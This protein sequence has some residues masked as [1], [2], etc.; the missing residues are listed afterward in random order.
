[1]MTLIGNGTPGPGFLFNSPRHIT[2]TQIDMGHSTLLLVS[3]AQQLR[4]L[5]SGVQSRAFVKTCRE[6]GENFEWDHHVF[7]GFETGLTAVPTGVMPAQGIDTI[8]DQLSQ[9]LRPGYLMV[10][11]RD[12]IRVL[13]RGLMPRLVLSLQVLRAGHEVQIQSF[14]QN[15]SAKK[16][17]ANS[18]WSLSA[19]QGLPL[20]LAF[21]S[22][23]AILNGASDPETGERLFI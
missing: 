17:V 10:S 3:P 22:F 5:S 11:D 18:S 2:P 16:L 4:D 23:R 15:Q 13:S 1:M 19:P 9:I 14:S 21:G 20:S 12:E 6:G 8:F 7:E